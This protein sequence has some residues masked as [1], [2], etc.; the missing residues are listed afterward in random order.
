MAYIP[1]VINKFIQTFQYDYIYYTI[2]NIYTTRFKYSKTWSNQEFNKQ[3]KKNL[4]ILQQ[5]LLHLNIYKYIKK[6]CIHNTFR[7]YYSLSFLQY[8]IFKIS[9][10]FCITLL[11]H[12]CLF[13]I[14]H[15]KTRTAAAIKTTVAMVSRQI[16]SNLP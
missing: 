16:F 4:G 5:T 7:I 10:W 14:L 12:D 11:L 1:L 2:L 3:Y 8:M 9:S 15:C 6:S 13:S